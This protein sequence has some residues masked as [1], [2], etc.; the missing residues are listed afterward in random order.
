MTRNL[1]HS[2]NPDS[3]CPRRVGAKPVSH[4]GAR[5]QFQ[6]G[7][8]AL[9]LGLLCAFLAACSADVRTSTFD[10]VQPWEQTEYSGIRRDGSYLRYH[11]NGKVECRGAYK[12]GLPHGDWLEFHEDGSARSTRSYAG[13][14]K[15]G[16]WI[17]WY[18][19]GR[20]RSEGLWKDGKRQGDWHYWKPDGELD[21]QES[22]VDGTRVSHIRH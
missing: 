13:G 8:L 10:G 21:L 4:D 7:Q 12:D 14:W 9:L 3:R 5:E 2:S 11:R 19:D 17:E 1:K 15:Q 16:H 18:A 20:K 22:W 6:I